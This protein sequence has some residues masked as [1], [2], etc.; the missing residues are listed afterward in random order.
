MTKKIE[1]L[2]VPADRYAYAFFAGYLGGTLD[3]KRTVSV[4]DWN[5]AVVATR[6]ELERT[7]HTNGSQA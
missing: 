5:A 7:D 1:R 2:K 3:Y 4:S 6:R